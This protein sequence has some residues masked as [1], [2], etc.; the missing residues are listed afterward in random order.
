V[1]KG[2]N[3]AKSNAGVGSGI[4]KG[5]IASSKSIVPSESIKDLKPI[6]KNSTS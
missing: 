6:I 1:K 2:A 5:R 3:R 4:G